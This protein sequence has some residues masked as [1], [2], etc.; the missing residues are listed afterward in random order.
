MALAEPLSGRASLPSCAWSSSA[1]TAPHLWEAGPHSPELPSGSHALGGWRR[2]PKVLYNLPC[3]C[4][5]KAWPWL[6]C[7]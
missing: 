2:R 3:F 5:E 1:G 6:K 7:P 4:V